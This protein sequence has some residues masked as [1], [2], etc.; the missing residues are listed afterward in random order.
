MNTHETEHDTLCRSHYRRLIPASS[1]SDC[2]VIWRTRRHTLRRALLQLED[3]GERHGW[4]SSPE[5]F[6]LMHVADATD[7]L[8]DLLEEL[9]K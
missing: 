9:P 7:V 6:H 4:V 3:A 5:G 2:E 8:R 1:C